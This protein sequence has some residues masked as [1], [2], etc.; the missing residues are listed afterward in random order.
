MANCI[1]CRF[2]IPDNVGEGFGQCSL[3]NDY[4][5]KKPGVIAIMAARVKL[6]NPHNIDI[7]WKGDRDCGK[8]ETKNE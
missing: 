4:I 3:Y 6:G 8:Y 5:A 2:S 7:F 1:S